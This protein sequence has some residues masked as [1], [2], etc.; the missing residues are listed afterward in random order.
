MNVNILFVLGVVLVIAAMGLSA[1]YQR[2]M[3]EACDR[4]NGVLID[5]FDG[6]QCIAG[7]TVLKDE[8]E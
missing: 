7:L 8:T 6:P 2:N 1:N 5:T 4:M 3:T